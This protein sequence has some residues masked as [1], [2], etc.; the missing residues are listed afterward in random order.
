MNSAED[1]KKTVSHLMDEFD[2]TGPFSDSVSI[3]EAME[4]I[5]HMRGELAQLKMSE[6]NIRRGLN[7]FKIEQPPS[8][9]IVNMEKVSITYINMSAKLVLW[10]TH[11]QA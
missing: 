6:S 2:S 4:F 9:L 8:N 1:F 10:S 7:I 11:G 5:S 3:S